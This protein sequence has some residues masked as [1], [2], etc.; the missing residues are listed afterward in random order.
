MAVNKVVMNTKN[1]LETVVD[2]TGDTVTPE[3][4][5]EGVTATAANGE[6]IVGVAPKDAVRYTAQS[7]TDAQKQQARANIGAVSSDEIVLENIPDYVVTEA[8]S[9]LDKVVDAQGDR[10]FVL[11][12]ITDMHYGSSDYIDGVI[13]ATQG[14]R[15]ISD[16]IKVD[17][18][19]VLGDYTDE[20]QMDTETAFADREECNALISQIK[21]DK[22][23]LKGN[24]DHTPSKSAQTFRTI[25]AYSDDVVWGSRIGGYFY[26]DFAAYKLRIIC[27]NTTEV[28]RDNLSVSDEQYQWFADTLDI[29]A[30]EDAAEWGI[31]LL[32]HHPLD[33]TVTD[34]TYKFVPIVNAYVSGASWTDGTVSCD[35]SG[36]NAAKIIGNIHGHL[37]NLLTSKLYIGAPGN[38]AQIDVYRMCT[39]ASRVDY[40]N[41]YSA[42]WAEDTWYNKTKNTAKDTSFC[43]YCIDLDVFTV[44]AFCYGAGY[45]REIAYADAPIVNLMDTIGY[46]DGMRVNSTGLYVGETGYVSTNKIPVSVGDVI[47]TKGV[48]FDAAEYKRGNVH[49]WTDQG[50]NSYL[51]TTSAETMSSVYIGASIDDDNNLELTILR[52]DVSEITLTGYGSGADLIVTRNQEINGGEEEPEEQI[53]NLIDTVGYTDNARYSASSHGTKTQSGYVCTGEITLSVGDVIRTSGVNFNS[54]SYQYCNI[55][56]INDTTDWTITTGS[57]TSAD[58]D[59]SLD[60]SNNLTITPKNVNNNL[61]IRLTGYGAGANLLV[62]R[63]QVI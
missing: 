15:H 62:T 11:G 33:W 16:R 57:G 12:A 29:S 20:H 8:M 48:N 60:A 4:L 55:A 58:L 54:N 59:F 6:K 42:P 46:Q 53:V 56:C 40:V 1:G 47:R 50:T 31:L 28:A 44:K 32:S 25:M 38:S 24:H 52:D 22:L 23:C 36:K 17:A 10:T 26:R 37:H 18:L 34:G 61:R 19:A 49:Y 27:V 2:L 3:T 13:H 14:F 9:V 35:Y 21:T 45:D 39:P 30:K 5:A 7:L 41:H 43:V 51:V 63:N